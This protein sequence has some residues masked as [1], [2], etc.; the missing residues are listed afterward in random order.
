MDSSKSLRR[1]AI[2]VA[3]WAVMGSAL[4]HPGHPHENWLAEV[5][6]AAQ[7]LAPLLALMMLGVGAAVAFR[8]WDRT[9]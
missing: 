9:H 2:A 7:G 5:L 6:H 4:A 8:S 3:G 1:A